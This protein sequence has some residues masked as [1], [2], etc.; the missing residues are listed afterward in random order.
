M[1]SRSRERT[2]SAG[3]RKGSVLGL[4]DDELARPEVCDVEKV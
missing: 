1:G 3:T 2:I 4:L